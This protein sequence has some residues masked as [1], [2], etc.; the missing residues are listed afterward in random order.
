MSC[1]HL[2]PVCARKLRFT[3]AFERVPRLNRLIDFFAAHEDFADALRWSQQMKCCYEQAN[4]AQHGFVVD[5]KM[6]SAQ[7]EL[8]VDA[9]TTSAQHGL[10]VD[11]KTTSA[12]HELA[13]LVVDALSASDPRWATDP[14]EVTVREVSKGGAKR[15]AFVFKVTTT[16]S[17]PLPSP[18]F[19]ALPFSLPPAPHLHPPP[20]LILVS[21]SKVT[22]PSGAAVGLHR[23]PSLQRENFL[24]RK[25]A[26]ATR[27][28]AKAGLAPPRLATGA[29]WFVEEWWPA[30]PCH[31]PRASNQNYDWT[32]SVEKWKE[33]GCVTAKIHQLPTSWWRPFKNA[34]TRQHPWAARLPPCS[35]VWLYLMVPM[36]AAE[37]RGLEFLAD[38]PSFCREYS[39]L[40]PIAPRH[41]LAKKTV[42]V[43]NDHHPL[44]MVD[45]TDG[46][47]LRV[48]DL[49]TAS[50]DLAIG[51]IASGPAS[52]EFDPV[53]SRA[54][55]QGYVTDLTPSHSH[56]PPP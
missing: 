56:S 1:I 3:T 28:F 34:A 52:C 17:Y 47:G 53:K 55:V 25:T 50:V 7:H 12:Q 54:Y 11:A 5:A 23:G 13:A 22:A 40:G 44:N 16:H 6:S 41:P 35:R 42:T 36:G 24:M 43:H 21:I 30:N 2:C 8:V 31:W 51:D 20:P 19:L 46:S 27:V 49:E 14:T 10:V 26:A 39:D 37:A 9:K 15:G 33:F 45:L 18:Y 38:H 32:E 4:T 48:I 29:D